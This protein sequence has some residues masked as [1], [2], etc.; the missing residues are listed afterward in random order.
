VRLILLGTRGEI[1]VRSRWHSRHTS[2][3]IVSRYGCVVIDFG[4]DWREEARN[5]RA[6]ALILTHAH[7]D[8]VAGLL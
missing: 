7:P 4:E 8:H 3:A 2:T 1:P 5:L 6:D